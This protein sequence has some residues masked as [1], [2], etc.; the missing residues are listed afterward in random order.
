MSS[1]MHSVAREAGVSAMTVSRVIR[2][3]P[4]VAEETRKRVH[5]ALRRQGYRRTPFHAAWEISRSGDRV[6]SQPP[7]AFL[8]G[9]SHQSIRALPWLA[10]IWQGVR[11][12]SEELGLPADCVIVNPANPG[13]K[14]LGGIL[15]SRG[16][17]GVVVGPFPAECLPIELPW[18]NLA[19]AAA[20][21]GQ[22]RPLRG[23]HRATQ[24][25]YDAMQGIFA[26]LLSAGYARPGH[27]CTTTD[28]ESG[29]Q[30]TGTFL[31]RQS[32]LPSGDQVPPLRLL[33]GD[34]G[35]EGEFLDWCRQF[36]PDVIVTANGKVA[37]WL[38]KGSRR[39]FKLPD[40]F[41]LDVNGPLSSDASGRDRPK[42][43]ATAPGH[44]RYFTGILYPG[45]L[46]GISAVELMA[47]QLRHYE[48][49]LPAIPK[50]LR[51]ESLFQKG[52]S[53]RLGNR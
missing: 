50:T 48:R 2:N 36:R 8:C 22:P 30:W 39:P 42:G 12:R 34:G 26:K 15:E 7:V 9:F 18:H 13:W 49:G 53:C 14:R 35:S 1:T 21:Y 38:G 47:A 32:W 4:K 16:V 29:I 40:L 5:D 20:D 45:R 19:V 11:T 27:V 6:A 46:I 17:R 41:M 10:S 33:P 51:V 31:E 25:H 52:K 23:V 28:D 24:N 43:G 44:A 3:D 37:E